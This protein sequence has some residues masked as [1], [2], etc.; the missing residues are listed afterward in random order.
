MRIPITRFFKSLA[1]LTIALAGGI[2]MAGTTG[3]SLAAAKVAGHPR[4]LA[5]VDNTAQL[6]LPHAGREGPSSRVIFINLQTCAPWGGLTFEGPS[7][8]ALSPSGK[9]F[10]IAVS[11]GTRGRPAGKILEFSPPKRAVIRSVRAA[12]YVN[13][14]PG[15]V[16]SWLFKTGPD[17]MLWL[18]VHGAIWGVRWPSM[19]ALVKLRVGRR[20]GEPDFF[21]IA[22]GLLFVDLAPTAGLPA[23]AAVARP[24]MFY[25]PEKSGR[26]HRCRMTTSLRG[27]PRFVSVRGRSLFG[28]EAL[29]DRFMRFSINRAGNLKKAR[30]T[31]VPIGKNQNVLGF[32]LF[33]NHKGIVLAA[34]GGDQSWLYFLDTRTGALLRKEEI[35]IGA[36]S[37]YVWGRRIYLVTSFGGGGEVNAAGKVLRRFGPPIWI[38]GGVET[39]R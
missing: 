17:G 9:N 37:L 39:A 13:N 2:F 36:N 14:F 28:M 22:G 8:V 15:G 11:G 32:R 7:V 21:P 23:L 33:G 35:P 31:E 12:V 6:A 16:D 18:P 24:R 3:Q 4:F 10:L 5:L 29:G 27:I 38:E 34:G 30:E 20:M 25:L 19:K 1:I 26:L